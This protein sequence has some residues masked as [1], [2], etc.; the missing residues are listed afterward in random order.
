M[1]SGLGRHMPAGPAA[2]GYPMPSSGM[3]GVTELDADRRA[4]LAAARRHLAPD[5][6]LIVEWYPPAWFDAAASGQGGRLG[7]VAIELA[8]V[9]RDG[10]LLSATVHYAAR[11]RRWHQEFTCRRLDL[12]GLLTSADFAFDRRLTPDR[13]WFSVRPRRMG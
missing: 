12:D 5:G 3:L 9:V 7:E 2:A 10:D 4:M 1:R 6:Q 11:G 8:D 13:A